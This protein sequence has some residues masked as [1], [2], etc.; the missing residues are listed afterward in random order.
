MQ[1]SNFVPTVNEAAAT[2]KGEYDIIVMQICHVRIFWWSVTQCIQYHV[3]LP[4]AQSVAECAKNFN[5]HACGI[6][7]GYIGISMCYIGISIGY[8]G[9][10]MCCRIGWGF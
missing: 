6:C 7:M 1:V 4:V 3:R 5:M 9:I 10:S 8:I 2:Y